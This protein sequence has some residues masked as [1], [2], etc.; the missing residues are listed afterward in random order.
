M[1]S[2]LSFAASPSSALWNGSNILSGESQ[3]PAGS[4]RQETPGPQRQRP[5]RRGGEEIYIG[6]AKYATHIFT[7]LLFAFLAEP[8]LGG[9]EQSGGKRAFCTF[10]CIYFCRSQR[11]SREPQDT[12]RHEYARQGA[13]PRMCRRAEAGS[14]MVSL[15]PPGSLNYYI[16]HFRGRAG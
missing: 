9:G 10:K 12:R 8:Q 2:C 6:A 3:Q 16:D 5:A 13:G 15:C 1:S 14:S 11:Q 4:S 7:S